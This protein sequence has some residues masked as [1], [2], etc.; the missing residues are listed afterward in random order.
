M[1]KDTSLCPFS[2]WAM[3]H[4]HVCTSKASIVNITSIVPSSTLLLA[5]YLCGSEAQQRQVDFNPLSHLGHY[6]N[7]ARYFSSSLKMFCDRL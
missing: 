7:Q 4:S 3:S 1:V 6:I 2:K 5:N